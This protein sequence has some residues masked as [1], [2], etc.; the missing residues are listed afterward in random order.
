M[1]HLNQK[2]K[3]YIK[4]DPYWSWCS[5]FFFVWKFCYTIYWKHKS[6]SE[7]RVQMNKTQTQDLVAVKVTVFNTQRNTKKRENVSLEKEVKDHVMWPFTASTALTETSAWS[8]KERK[9]YTRCMMFLGAK[10]KKI[11]HSSLHWFC[12]WT[13]QFELMQPYHRQ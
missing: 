11:T 5:V 4:L 7:I 8:Q 1:F 9:T 12:Y 6:Q 13:K 2:F 10:I 3:F